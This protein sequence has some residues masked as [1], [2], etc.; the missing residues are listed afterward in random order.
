[1][2]AEDYLVKPVE[3]ARL[4]RRITRITQKQRPR[5][6]LIDDDPAVHDLLADQL[7]DYAIDGAFDG[8]AGIV[9][10][11]QGRTT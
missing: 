2:G 10:A 8:E 4:I 7:S 6:L 5:L 9:A 3:P 1:M 11:K